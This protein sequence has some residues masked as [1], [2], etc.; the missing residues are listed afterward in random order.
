MPKKMCLDIRV[1]MRCRWRGI[2][3]KTWIKVVKEYLLD[4]EITSSL[5][6][7]GIPHSLGGRIHVADPEMAGMSYDDDEKTNQTTMN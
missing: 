4:L 3:L 6:S 5:W 1:C 7:L 2:S